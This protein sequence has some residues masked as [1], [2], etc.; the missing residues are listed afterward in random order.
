MNFITHFWLNIYNRI[1]R[2]GRNAIALLLGLGLSLA[3]AIPSQ[4]HWADLAV[5]D[6]QI[7]RNNVELNLTI[8]TGLVDRFDD[9]KDRKLSELEIT[10]HQTKL[11]QF[12]NEK[13]QLTAAGQKNDVSIV[14]STVAKTLSPN[15]INTPDTHSTLLLQYR[16]AEPVT[17]LQMNYDLFVPGV[18]TARCLAQVFRDGKVDNIVFT[19]TAKT[20]D[21]I[22]AP[23]LQQITSFIGLGIEHI[24]TGY[25]HIL[26]L[27]SLLMLGGGLKYLIKVV[28]AFSISH[29]ITLTLAVLN[30]VSVPSRWVE[31]VIAL[32]IAYIAAENLWRKEPNLA[33]WQ[34]AFGFG[35]IHGLGFSSALQELALPRNNLAVS[36]V[37]FSAGIEIGQISIVLLTYLGLTY[38]RKLPWDLTVR[39]LISVGV[40]VMSAI[41]VWERAF[42][43]A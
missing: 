2:F 43:G 10:K 8:P 18:S 9:D 24:F 26:F 34:L 32:S 1:P 4:A 16:W 40:I 33:R 23:I 19:P 7:D 36:L 29:S 39:R 37:S 27:I 3:L 21:L 42:M 11:Q 13:I 28:T 41:W 38:L 6:I 14:R 17:Q 5:A 31:I 12:L 15:L 35:L 25:D 20:A 30:I 22:D